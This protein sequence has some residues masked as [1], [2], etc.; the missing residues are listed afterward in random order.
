MLKCPRDISHQ[1]NWVLTGDKHEGKHWEGRINQSIL[2]CSG[3]LTTLAV[4][5]DFD[6]PENF[7]DPD[8]WC[9]YCHSYLDY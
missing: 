1:I 3:C 6:H 4:A 7:D 8:E 9:P 2:W 5:Y